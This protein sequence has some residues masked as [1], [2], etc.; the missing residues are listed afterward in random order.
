MF[1]VGALIEDWVIMKWVVLNEEV[2]PIMESSTK[3]IDV[4]GGG[5]KAKAVVEDIVLFLLWGIP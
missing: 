1:G 3:F 2:Q 5:V 4:K